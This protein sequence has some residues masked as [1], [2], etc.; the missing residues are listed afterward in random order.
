VRF[1]LEL[2]HRQTKLV[3]DY[4]FENQLDIFE[5]EVVKQYVQY[6]DQVLRSDY[7][8]AD[9]VLDF[10]RRQPHLQL[11]NLNSRS[12]IMIYRENQMIM[13]QVEGIQALCSYTGVDTSLKII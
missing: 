4:L 3:Q 1:D 13:N 12:L 10:Q 2:K 8:Y 6:S 5:H 9:W 11:V 7:I